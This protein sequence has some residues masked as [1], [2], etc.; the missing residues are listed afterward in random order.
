MGG[1]ITVVGGMIDVV[2]RGT[3][4]KSTGAGAEDTANAEEDE[5]L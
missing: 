1:T 4:D 3:V 5:E 2:E